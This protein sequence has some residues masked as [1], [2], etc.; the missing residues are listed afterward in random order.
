[1]NR[2]IRNCTHS[3]S[4]VGNLIA[5]ATREDSCAFI[6]SRSAI[7]EP[8]EPRT[9][10]WIIVVGRGFTEHKRWVIHL[11]LFTKEKGRTGDFGIDSNGAGHARPA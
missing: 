8:F 6:R 3:M 4:S 10:R 7:L 11:S 9:T 5:A 1:M 2:A